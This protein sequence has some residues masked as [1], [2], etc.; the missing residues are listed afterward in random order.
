MRTATILH[1]VHLESKVRDPY[2]YWYYEFSFD[3]VSG[4]FVSV[5]SDQFKTLSQL[6]KALRVPP[7]PDWVDNAHATLF[8]AGLY[9]SW[10]KIGTRV[11]VK[12]TEVKL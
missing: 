3:R 9:M 7:I 10:N 6:F 5:N 11:R 2:R 12:L 8:N 1:E 4:E